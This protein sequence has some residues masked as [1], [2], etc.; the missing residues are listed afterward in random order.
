ML[1][2]YKQELMALKTWHIIAT[3]SLDVADTTPLPNLLLF[4]T[5]TI[6]EP[7]SRMCSSISA[8]TPK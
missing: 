8:T 2:C 5:M 3:D 1:N 7:L 4:Q 6:A